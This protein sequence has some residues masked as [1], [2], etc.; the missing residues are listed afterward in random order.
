MKDD[1]EMLSQLLALRSQLDALKDTW[2]FEKA[3]SAIDKAA[4]DAADALA[5]KLL[6]N[7]ER[8]A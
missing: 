2:E 8:L 6:E 7:G 1:I 3:Y 5:K 4:R